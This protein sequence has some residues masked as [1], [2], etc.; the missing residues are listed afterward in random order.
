MNLYGHT[1]K[2][3]G[4]CARAMNQAIK[5]ATGKDTSGIASAKNYGPNLIKAGASRV[6]VTNGQYQK[7]D[8]MIYPSIP[9]HPHGHAQIYSGN[10][11][12]V[13][14]FKQRDV[15]PGSGY[16][17]AKTGGTVYRFGN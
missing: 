8:I 12:W 4:Y 14:D 16:R 2:P 11:V 1:T 5:A 7:G 15:Y 6:T 9:G 17:N 13:S 3:G 10:G